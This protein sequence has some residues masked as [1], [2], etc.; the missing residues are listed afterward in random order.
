MPSDGKADPCASPPFPAGLDPAAARRQAAALL[1]LF[2]GIVYGVPLLLGGMSS[3]GTTSALSALIVGTAM[4]LAALRCLRRDADWRDS[5]A[6][7]PL[8]FGR[9]AR[10]S[11]F[12]FLGIYAAN[13]ALTLTYVAARGDV[14]AL[15]ARRLNWL[16]ALAEVPLELIAPLVLF[17]GLWEETVFRGF[18]L[19]RL[20]AAIPAPP[21]PAS[22]R[23]RDGFAAALTAL[24][25][26]LGHGY[27]GLLGVLQ[28]TLAGAVLGGLVLWKKSLWPAIGAHLLIDLFGLLAIRALTTLLR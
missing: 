5:L 20:R 27:Q 7:R 22:R 2:Y 1:G 24:C 8:P 17:I 21:D 10:W 13:L 28:T 19:G 11:L 12:G 18:L 23:R 3:R 25:F 6:L 9:A 14:Q 15:A 16:G 4:L 26:G